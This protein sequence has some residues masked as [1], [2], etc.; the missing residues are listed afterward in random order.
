MKIKAKK[1]FIVCGKIVVTK[2][3]VFEVG[4]LRWN[5]DLP[6]LV[7]DL[8]NGHIFGNCP[9][10]DFETVTNKNRR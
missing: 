5:S 9:K 6:S 3:Q 4:N 2:G 8:P 1:D 10:S 7:L